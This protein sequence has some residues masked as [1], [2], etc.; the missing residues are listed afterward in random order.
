[1]SSKCESLRHEEILDR[2]KK[3]A[4][5]RIEVLKT[6]WYCS[7]STAWFPVIWCLKVFENHFMRINK[8]LVLSFFFFFLHLASLQ[9][10]TARQIFFNYKVWLRFR[11]FFFFC[12][13]VFIMR[14]DSI[15]LLLP[16]KRQQ[17]EEVNCGGD[18]NL[19]ETLIHKIQSKTDNKQA[20]LRWRGILMRLRLKLRQ[21]AASIKARHTAQQL[22]IRPLSLGFRALA[23]RHLHTAVSPRVEN[24]APQILS[25]WAPRF[26][27]SLGV[28]SE[29]DRAG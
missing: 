27:F 8:T 19:E 3:F 10:L 29:R 13:V 15:R 16:R 6:L 5:F 22:Q 12:T 28:R 2:E 17:S 23:Y 18:F 25:D 14:R 4:V 26:V 7:Q 1:M 24:T 9:L 20:R 11:S 21:W